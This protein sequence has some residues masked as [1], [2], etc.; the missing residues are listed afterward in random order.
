MISSL[1]FRLFTHHYLFRLT[2]H[3]TEQQRAT[4]TPSK[5]MIF[6]HDAFPPI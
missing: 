5:I 1:T 6:I 4:F 2:I 3:P